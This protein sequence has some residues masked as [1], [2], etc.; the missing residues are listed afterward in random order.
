MKK[1]Q[2][3]P[4]PGTG[5]AGFMVLVVVLASSTAAWALGWPPFAVTD[6]I[7]VPRGGT[8]VTLTSGA[9]SVLANDF[10]LERD[11]LTAVLTKDVKHGSLL[12][13]EDGTFRYQ[14]DGS[15][16]KDD[17]FKYRASDG[18]GLSREATVSISIEDVPN[19]PPFVVSNVSDQ[20]ATEGTSYRLVL[21][22]NFAD[23]DDDD[24]LSFD[25][26]GL[27]RSGSLQFDTRLAILSGTPVADDVRDRPYRIRVTA[28]DRQGA[29]ARLEFDLLVLRRNEPPVVVGS[30]PDQEAIEGIAYRLNLSTR[31]ADPDD[32]DVLRFSASGLPGSGSLQ[33][34]AVTGVLSGTP[35]RA[36]ARDEP[37]TVEVRAR[38]RAGATARLSFPLRILRDN[39]SDVVLDIAP[40]SNAVTVGEDVRWNIDIQNKGP[41]DLQD[42]QLSAGWVTSGPELTVTA[43]QGCVVTDNESSAPVMDCELGLVAAGESLSLTVQSV[44]QAD[45]DNSLLG[46]VSADDPN[47]EDN[48]D[49]ASA[50]VVAAFSEGPTQIVDLTGAAVKTGDLDGDGTIDIVTTGNESLVFF[51]NG[52]RA[53]TT[54][55]SSLGADSGGTA[56]ALV[57]WN[58][59]GW[60]DIAVGGLSGRTVEVY[61]NDGSGG[62]ASA[63]SLQGA[64]I[65]NL[66]DLAAVDVDGDGLSELLAT[67]SGGTAILG[68]EADG[69][70]GVTALASDAG[71][72]LAV[73]DVDQDGDPDFV[74][75]LAADRRI[76]FFYNGGDGSITGVTS[77]DA[78]SVASVNFGDINGD[79]AADLLL[80]TDGDD[81]NAPQNKVLYQQGGGNFA[82]GPSFGASPVSALVSG[83]VN[84][85]GWP[86]IVAINE[87]G[88]HQLYLGAQD[89][90]LSL[91]REQIV[92]AGMQRGA[93]TDFNGDESLDLILVGIDAGVLEIHANNGL[94]RLGLGDRVE[95]EIQLLG[96]ASVSIPAGQEYVDPGATAVDDIDGDISDKIEVSGTVN[97][98]I[99]GTQTITYS[100][101]DRAG[102]RATATRTVAVGVNEGRGGGGGGRSTPLFVMALLLVL[103]T[104]AA[105]SPLRA[106][107]K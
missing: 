38:D 62:F 72:G 18:T 64:G 96:E 78:G 99:V 32:G 41:A 86:D 14:N 85:D 16:H 54:P 22:G 98:T 46:V 33:L 27:P 94:G 71:R 101:S 4:T 74:V 10:D 58:G 49:R 61:V 80:A 40:E 60:P 44:Q 81:M 59:D 35:I 97:T 43:P 6:S 19:E 31:F 93:L 100:V 26:D 75:L 5:I 2:A 91:A 3:R 103:L 105:R 56:L 53:V 57:E 12:L 90:G 77:L 23:P 42:G 34:D 17:E 45:G 9:Q 73:A 69:G 11:K 24:V 52:N 82:P 67:G 95:P 29:S 76:D 55:G 84:A 102:N 15:N 51:N 20:T 47:P 36:D 88:V 89:G 7:T 1:I 21:A 63:A 66:S 39:R 50:A 65:G 106:V 13:R 37:Y 83:D 92:S 48:Q 8:A 28:T 107:F 79:G 70:I 87:A 30:V 104:R 68:R 25:I